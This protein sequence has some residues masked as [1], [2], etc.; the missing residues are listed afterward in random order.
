MWLMA[1]MCLLKMERV[2]S[3]LSAI[4]LCVSA[5]LLLLFMCECGGREF[6]HIPMVQEEGNQTL[7][8]YNQEGGGSECK[9]CW[10]CCVCV[11]IRGSK[12]VTVCD[13]T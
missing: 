1:I 12:I 2:H 10:L 13:I 7:I 8:K 11:Q 4:L 3:V 5:V 9:V 6:K